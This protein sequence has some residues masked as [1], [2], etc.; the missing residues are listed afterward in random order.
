MWW[1]SDKEEREHVAQVRQRLPFQP[2]AL[3]ADLPEH[4]RPK[5]RPVPEPPTPSTAPGQSSARHAAA[6]APATSPSP[7]TATTTRAT[8]TG[9]GAIAATG[10]FLA[11]TLATGE[12]IYAMA[13]ACFTGLFVGCLAAKRPVAAIALPLASA[14]AVK[15]GGPSVVLL[16]ILVGL[17]AVVSDLFRSAGSQQF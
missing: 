13:F 16:L 1:R 8:P 4:Q 17:G 5:Q 9:I 3:L 12:P 2:P 11:M 6:P 15:I 7:A 14:G 10:V